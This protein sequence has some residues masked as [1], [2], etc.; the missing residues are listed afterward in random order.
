M[1]YAGYRFTRKMIEAIKGEKGIVEPSYV[2]LPGIQGGD[3]IAKETGVDFFSVPIQ[4]G[5]S[6]AE[7]AQNILSSVSS[8]EK[9]LLEACKEGLKGSIDK[10]VKFVT[11]SPEV[12]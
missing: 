2:Y 3:A 11:N 9:K 6:G 5:P 4:L 8:D 1:A 7:S 10:G 12:K